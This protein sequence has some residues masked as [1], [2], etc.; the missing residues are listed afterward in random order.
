MKHIRLIFSAILLSLVVPCG[1][2]Q[3]RQDSLAI[4]HAQWHTDTL[5]HGAVCMYTNIHVFDSP[6]QISIIKYDPKKYKTQIVQAP[7]MTMTSLLAKENQAEAAINGSYFNVKTGAPTTFIRLDGIVRGETTRAEAFRTDGA[8][9]TDKNKIKIHA[10]DSITS[11]KLGKKYKNI[12]A[13]GPL[14]LK[15]GVRQMA[16]TFP[17]NTGKATKGNAHS[18]D[19]PQG[20]FK[21]GKEGADSQFDFLAGSTLMKPFNRRDP[22]QPYIYDYYRQKGYTVCR[23]PEGYNSQK[24]ADK[25]LLVDTDTTLKKWLPYV[26]ERE[27]GKLGLEFM[28]QA[29]IEKLYKK[30]NKKGF[31]MMIEGASIDHASHPRDIATAIKE[32]IEFDRSV[33]LAYEFYKKHPDE[34]LIIVTADHETGGLTIG[35]TTTH[36]F[37]WEYVNYQKMSKESL[38]KLFQKMR[39]TGEIDTWEK[40]KKILAENTGLWDKI[41]V[42]AG[43]EAQLMQCYYE[44]IV[45]KNSKQEITLYAKSEPLV[46]DAIAL[47]NKKIGVGWT[48]FSH[49]G[50]FVPFYAIGCQARQ[51]GAL[52]DNI[53]IPNTIRKIMKIK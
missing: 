28:V 29:G 21:I 11:K 3:T 33:R 53:E 24:N 34:T 13:A 5:Q 7:Q 4:A 18:S 51:F 40:T 42:N 32:T 50:G 8:I 26:I 6:Q 41:P 1:Y 47:L 10:F 30:K 17:E 38:S 25:I 9:S 37:N 20:F 48:S 31:F 39:E 16:P 27:P 19:V 45:K 36:P 49:T 52:N 22:S 2:A 43:E 23:G 14:L 12:L 35:E 15:N 44:T 46:A